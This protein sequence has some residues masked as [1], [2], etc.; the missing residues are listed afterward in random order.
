MTTAVIGNSFKVDFGEHV[1]RLD[2]HSETQ[3][4]WTALPAEGHQP[5]EQAMTVT[6]SRTEVRPDVFMVYWSEL[7]LGNTVVHV[8][9]FENGKVWTNITMPGGRF[10][11]MS[12]SLTPLPLT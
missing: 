1:F 9:D 11:N 12:G 10:L 2:F 6:I 4:T 8:Q 7:S 5:T 3:M